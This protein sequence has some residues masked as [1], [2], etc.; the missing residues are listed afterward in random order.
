M[1]TSDRNDFCMCCESTDCEQVSGTG[2]C[3]DTEV[4]K[5]SC[6]EYGSWANLLC[7]GPFSQTSGLFSRVL[8]VPD[9][10]MLC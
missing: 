7:D 10:I 6:L 8:Q 4:A 5:G 2:P 1:L 3:R 9:E